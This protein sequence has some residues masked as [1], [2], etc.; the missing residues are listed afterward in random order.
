MAGAGALVPAAIALA[1]F[2]ATLLFQRYIAGT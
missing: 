2:A 1:G